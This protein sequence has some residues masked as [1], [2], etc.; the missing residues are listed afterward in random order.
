MSEGTLI[1][2][3]NRVRHR[4]PKLYQAI[5]AVRLAQ[6]A[7]R[8]EDVLA[9]KSAHSAIYFRKRLGNMRRWFR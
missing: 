2:H 9:A 5:R 1:T 7:D 3:I 8:H 6:L 4:H